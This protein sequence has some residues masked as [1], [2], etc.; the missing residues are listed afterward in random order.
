MVFCGLCKQTKDTVY[1]WYIE[2]QGADGTVNKLKICDDCAGLLLRRMAKKVMGIRDDQ[3][4][5]EIFKISKTGVIDEIVLNKDNV[6]EITIALDICKARR[7]VEKE[8]AGEP[9]ADE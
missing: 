6:L 3:P 4:A 5:P 1:N 7:W 2:E 9:I 8:L